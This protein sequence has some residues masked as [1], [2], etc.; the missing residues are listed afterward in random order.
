MCTKVRSLFAATRAEVNA[1]EGGRPW[2]FE[3]D[4]VF[5]RFSMYEARLGMLHV[6]FQTADDFSKLEK[7]ELSVEKV[8]NSVFSDSSIFLN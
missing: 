1:V 6:I 3:T 4:L 8:S 7:V 2:E 5:A